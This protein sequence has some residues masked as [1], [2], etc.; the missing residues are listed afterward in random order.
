MMQM[1]TAVAVLFTILEQSQAVA[2]CDSAHGGLFTKMT[3]ET[4]CDADEM[5]MTQ[6]LCAM[7]WD[8]LGMAYTNGNAA[9]TYANKATAPQ[10]CS[11]SSAATSTL[12][13]NEFAQGAVALFSPICIK[14]FTTVTTTTAAAGNTTTAAGGGNTTATTAA[15]TA[16]TGALVSCVSPTSSTGLSVGL[17]SAVVFARMHM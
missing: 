1:A 14:N 6:P 15:T 13:W 4:V 3:A 10:G 7:A 12:Q 2:R 5:I 11:Q 9:V 16:T 8:C 17:I